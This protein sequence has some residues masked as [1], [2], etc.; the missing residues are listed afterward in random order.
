MPVNLEKEK[1]LHKHH[2]LVNYKDITK[3]TPIRAVFFTQSPKLIPGIPLRERIHSDLKSKIT[4]L[5]GA[6][7]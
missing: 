2:Q 7:K 5:L 6:V 1:G 3:I 4:N